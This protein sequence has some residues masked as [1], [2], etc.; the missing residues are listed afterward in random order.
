MLQDTRLQDILQQQPYPLLFVTLCGSHLYGFSSPDSDFDLRGVHI[1]PVREVVGL[2]EGKETIDF[3]R[4]Y[5]GLEVD[6]VTHDLRKF[7]K[8]LLGKN[9]NVLEA[10]Y[11]P[12]V[13]T[14]TPEHEELK[15]LAMKCV[16]RYY[17]YHYLGF[18][19]NQIK[20]FLKEQPHRVKPLLYIYRVLLCGL[21]LM[22]SGQL[23]P[24]LV[25]LNE[26][27][28]LPYIPE[29]IERKQNG[30]ERSLLGETDLSFHE[31]EIKRLLDELEKSLQTSALP[32]TP[33][34]QAKEALNDLL[35]RLRL[36]GV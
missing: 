21:Y 26:E 23:E 22:R 18:T 10:I 25:R 3:I 36:R 12:L 24:H 14:T 4:N 13:L 7:L 6:L 19:N 32:E 1:L 16:T 34:L 28:K 17:A 9:G 2:G 5:D 29:L 15:A 30:A 35:V 31:Q 8:L 20:L 11:S 27:F 33:D